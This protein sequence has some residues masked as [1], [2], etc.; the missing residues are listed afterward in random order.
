M[1]VI[2]SLGQILSVGGRKRKTDEQLK[3]TWKRHKKNET[4]RTNI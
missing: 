2:I 1:L 3:N 4:I